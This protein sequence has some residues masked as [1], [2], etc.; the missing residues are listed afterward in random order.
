MT[1]EILRYLRGDNT[2]DSVD[3]RS[4]D[5]DNRGASMKGL[6]PPAPPETGGE[7]FTGIHS[8]HFE[9]PL[10]VKEGVG[11]GQIKGGQ[12]GRGKNRSHPS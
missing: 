4:G 7:Q 11:G 6:P 3:F 9:S 1:G 8:P 5:S 12:P 10:L 2:L